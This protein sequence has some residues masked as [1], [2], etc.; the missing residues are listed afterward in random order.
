MENK[1]YNVSQMAAELTKRSIDILSVRNN[2]VIIDEDKM[3]F[4]VVDT[5]DFT[6]CT[7]QGPFHC[8]IFYGS[9]PN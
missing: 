8:W 4:A 2:R 6:V 7:N 1:F 5:F 9:F 3:L